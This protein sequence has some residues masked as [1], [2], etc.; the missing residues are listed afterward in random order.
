M[1][2]DH[3]IDAYDDLSDL[4]TG[5]NE[6]KIFN[7]QSMVEISVVIFCV[8]F[9]IVIIMNNSIILVDLLNMLPITALNTDPVT[10]TVAVQHP[11]WMLVSR[12]KLWVFFNVQVKRFYNNTI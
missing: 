2:K 6:S 12:K 1:M 7:K 8:C 5:I 4:W 3:L 11:C 10:R 9:S